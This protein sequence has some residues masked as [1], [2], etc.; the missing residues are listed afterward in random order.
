M[1][2]D[3]NMK[4]VVIIIYLGKFQKILPYDI[5]EDKVAEVQ[6]NRIEKP[7]NIWSYFH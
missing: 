5:N 7:E 1:I 4:S 2:L 6:C 3:M